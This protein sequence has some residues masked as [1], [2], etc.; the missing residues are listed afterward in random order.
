[1][2][3]SAI[4]LITNALHT[5]DSDEKLLRIKGR[6]ALF[7]QTMEVGL[8]SCSCALIVPLLTSFAE[9]GVF[10]IQHQRFTAHSI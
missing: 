4:A 6:I 7:L 1:M 5:I 9:L 10:C 8:F 3:Q 2:C